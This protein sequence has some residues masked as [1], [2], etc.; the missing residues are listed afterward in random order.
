MVANRS[1]VRSIWSNV[2]I[3][4]VVGMTATT[5]HARPVPGV[6][7]SASGMES[8]ADVGYDDGM[9][10]IVTRVKGRDYAI[11]SSLPGPIR[12]FD[13]TDP[14]RP[15]LVSS[16]PCGGNQAF[17]QISHDGK[18]LVVAEGAPHG[19]DRCMPPE[20]MGFYTI[21]ISDP[22]KPRWLG[23]ATVPRSG[24]T[25]TTHPTK[26]IVYVSYGDVAP[27]PTE[28]PEF[29][30]WSIKNPAHPTRLSTAAVTGYHGP[31]DIA[32]NADGTR[33]VMSS[34]S[35]IQVFDTTDPAR[36]KELQVLQCP[37]CTHNHESHFTPDQKHIIVGD[38][39]TG[40]AASPCP[41]G[42]LY[43]Y[44]WDAKNSPHMTLVGEWQPAEAITPQGA[45]T[46]APLCT[47]HVFDISPDGTKVAASWHNAGVRVV[48]IT[49]MDG[50]G[51][52]PEGPG[53]REIGWAVTDGADSWSAKFDRSGKYVF[54]NDRIH[55][56]QV[57]GVHGS[58]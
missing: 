56:F 29:E 50:A 15:K 26:P 48:D 3:L 58:S 21:D 31:H 8:V 11:S 1:H 10:L 55:G 57:F 28:K 52:G 2:A 24:H 27:L 43:F 46:N 36:P 12:F 30:I 49:S 17:L 35:A 5:V 25:V 42:A 41:M 32:F 37:G 51:V 22:R 19:I 18:T 14:T 6:M 38:E 33:A 9:H 40:G 44:D 13:V 47:P 54:V 23:Y 7:K 20:D 39:T 34:M 4:L 45:P 53:A 16:V